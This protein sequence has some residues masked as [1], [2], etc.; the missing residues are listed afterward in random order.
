MARQRRLPCSPRLDAV[1]SNYFCPEGVSIKSI[2]AVTARGTTEPTALRSCDIMAETL[3]YLLG[4]TAAE[5]NAVRLYYIWRADGD[6]LTAKATEAR[7]EAR[8]RSKRR[9]FKTAMSE[10]QRKYDSKN[11][12]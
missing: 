12:R 2:M 8:K 1:L 3:D 9:L 10:V 11:P 7:Q 5:F 6:C 4:L